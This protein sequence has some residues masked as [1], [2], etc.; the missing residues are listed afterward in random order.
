MSPVPSFSCAR[1]RSRCCWFLR[2]KKKKKKKNGGGLT[3]GIEGEE[4]GRAR[5]PLARREYYTLFK[6]LKRRREKEMCV[7]VSPFVSRGG[8]GGERGIARGRNKIWIRSYIYIYI[9]IYNSSIFSKGKK[10]ER[11][12]EVYRA[13]PSYNDY[14]KCR[15]SLK[16]IR[17]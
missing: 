6:F 5:G 14:S 4:G 8:G 2:E 11:E 3:P 9:Y 16:R 17:I 12:R 7:Y 10:R 1:S 13:R 15:T